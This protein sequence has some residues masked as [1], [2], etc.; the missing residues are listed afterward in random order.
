M[1]KAKSSLKLC[2][3]CVYLWL[4]IFNCE[5]CNPSVRLI[6]SVRLTRSAIRWPTTQT[7]P[8]W[9]QTKGVRARWSR[10]TRRPRKKSARGV[11]SPAHPQRLES[12]PRRRGADIRGGTERGRSISSQGRSGSTRFDPAVRPGDGN[13][14]HI[15]RD[16]FLGWDRR[17]A[18]SG[19]GRGARPGTGHRWRSRRR[20]RRSRPGLSLRP[21]PPAA[22]NAAPTCQLRASRRSARSVAALRLGG[23]RDRIQDGALEDDAIRL[24]AA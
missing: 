12:I 14:G 23:T 10:G 9:S 3:T 13:T 18:G 11:V 21:G 24:P 7:M 16:R 4:R 22:A 2:F 1:L 5:L 8:S 17:G 19:V 15:E 6:G 20:P